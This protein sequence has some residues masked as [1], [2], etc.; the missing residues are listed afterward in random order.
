[1]F[2]VHPCKFSHFTIGH[3]LLDNVTRSLDDPVA[4]PDALD[5]ATPPEFRLRA[6]PYQ[7]ILAR[8]RIDVP[9][10][11]GFCVDEA[12]ELL[13]DFFVELQLRLPAGHDGGGT[14]FR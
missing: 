1:M 14:S 12:L 2:G 11:D 4:P 9:C 10:V 5:T 8:L 6:R 7:S 13:L 3:S